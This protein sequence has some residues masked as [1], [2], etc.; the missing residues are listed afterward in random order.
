MDLQFI[1]MKKITFLFAAL[2]FTS[3]LHA[4]T[5]YYDGAIVVGARAQALSDLCH[6]VQAQHQLRPEQI[7]YP[8]DPQAFPPGML[9]TLTKYD[10][11]HV[12]NYWYKNGTWDKPGGINTIEPQSK[13]VRYFEDGSSQNFYVMQAGYYEAVMFL[14]SGGFLSPPVEVGQRFGY[15]WLLATRTSDVP[16]RLVSYKNGVLILDVADKDPMEDVNY[17][18]RFRNVYVAIPKLHF[19]EIKEH[20]SVWPVEPW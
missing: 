10:W 17:P 3:T 12:T 9:D 7:L 2:L 13:L 4:Q 5:T 11:L 18:R 16:Q 20:A 1:P 6:Q 14:N 8:Q 19:P 15:T